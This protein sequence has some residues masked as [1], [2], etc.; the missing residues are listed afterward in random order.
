Q[1]FFWWEI[2]I[3]YYT[4]VVLSWFGLVRDLRKP[5]QKVLTSNLV[6]GSADGASSARNKNG[7]EAAL[8]TPEGGRIHERPATNHVSQPATL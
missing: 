3:S 4:L 5:P 8:G 2:D 1:G 7:T 6:K